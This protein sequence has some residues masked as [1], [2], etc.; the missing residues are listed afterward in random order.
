[1]YNGLMRKILAIAKINLAQ[2]LVYRLS[3]V[4]W[5][6]RVILSLFLTF[7]LWSAVYQSR[8]SIFNYSHR[9]IMTYIL[10]IYVIGDLV[11]SSR[12][13]DLSIQ[14]RNGAIINQL[15]KPFP[16]LHNLFTREVTDKLLNL[17]FS[18]FEVGLVILLFKPALFIQ[19]DIL[20][21]LLMLLAIGMGIVISFFISFAISLVAFWSAEVWG[22][23]FVFMTLITVLSG[24]YFPLD[25][26]PTLF[27]RLLL[28]TPF[29][30]FTYLP[31][32]IFLD[33][34]SFQYLGMVGISLVWVV[35]SY[36]FAR[37]LWR[38]GIREFSFFGR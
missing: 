8:L 27:Y 15:L 13:S 32:K 19:T 6:V 36:F 26:L 1:L 23:R 25:I 31:T 16:F 20:T 28:L 12:V 7:F 22:P 24:S 5:R 17:F 2:Y 34:F 29:P 38:K 9:Q 30:Y 37:A 3:F 18:I 33:G 21:I 11:Y 10:L 4:L 14:I 35:L